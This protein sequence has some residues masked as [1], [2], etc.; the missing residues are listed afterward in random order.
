MYRGGLGLEREI[1][2]LEDGATLSVLSDKN[3]IPPYGVNGGYPGAPNRFVV[4]R[5]GVEVE[6]SSLPGKIAAFPLHAGDVVVMRTAGG[7]GFGNPSRR[8]PSLV[9]R[10]VEF[11]YISASAAE[12]VYGKGVPLQL[13]IERLG[14]GLRFENGK[15]RAVIA[16]ATSVRLGLEAGALIE[17]L[18][19]GPSLRAWI[20]VD[21]RIPPGHIGL[22]AEALEIIGSDSDSVAVHLIGAA[23]G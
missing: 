8:D 12:K 2:V 19:P 18:A 16:P 3:V 5:H 21:G 4:Q 11:G 6:P 22:D 10:D 1:R 17:L 23:R 14:G 13:R 15:R 9:R 7:G 20:A